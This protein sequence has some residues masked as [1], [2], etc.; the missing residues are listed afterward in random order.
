M[1]SLLLKVPLIILTAVGYHVGMT[2]PNP[3]PS[4]EEQAKALGGRDVTF[5]ERLTRL[6]PFTAKTIVATVSAIEIAVALAKL[7]PTSPASTHI[8]AL[9]C[10]GRGGAMNLSLSA[11]SLVGMGLVCLGGAIRLACYRELGRLF[12]YELTL[13][14]EHK[15]V[16]SGP[17]S[18]VRHPSYTGGTILA[19][20]MTICELG[21]GT[22]W[23][24]AG[25]IRTIP[26]Q[27]LAV[28]WGAILAYSGFIFRRAVGEDDLMRKEFKGQW[29]E[30]AARVPYRFVPW[31]A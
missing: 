24:E 6:V 20:G 28:V 8:L 27:A 10:S 14:K 11:Q 25:I 1:P 22:W 13:R 29:D 3:P 2:P 9:F 15:L 16:T 4:K 21:S 26:G 12:T 18:I 23:T 17:Y 30:W 5:R 31:L 19:V 7:N